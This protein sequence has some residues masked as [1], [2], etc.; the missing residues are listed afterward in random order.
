MGSGRARAAAADGRIDMASA[1]T[2]TKSKANTGYY[3]YGILPGDVELNSEIHGV[4]DPP[5]QIRLVRSGDLAALVSE[6]NLSRPLG[7]PEDLEA[8]EEILDSII[9]S[10]PVLPMR[11]G[12]VLTSEDAVAEE[13]LEANHD[14]FA[15]TLEQLEGRVEYL[16]K[17]RYM[18]R[19]IL[20]EIL[21]EDS[22]AAQLRE[23]IRGADAD[24]TRELRIQLGEIVN[25]A[26]AAA[27]E[28][29]TR[30]FLD[31]MKDHCDAS[32]V[33]DPTHELDAVNVALLIDAS[34][35]DELERIVEELANQWE[36]LVQLRALGPMAPYDFVAAAQEPEG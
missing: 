13:L 16:V 9:V 26:V 29:A 27:R 14:D 11:F 25:N 30:Q 22:G 4:G 2:E 8:H 24:A 19:A 21:S 7:T 1:P 18:E 33:R 32:L 23:Q 17:G 5:G 12:A 36:G 3:V 10:S 34:E 6:V 31:A 28:Q 15:E 35:A 20:E